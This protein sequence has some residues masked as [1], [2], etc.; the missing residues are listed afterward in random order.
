MAYIGVAIMWVNFCSMLAFGFID[1]L[2]NVKIASTLALMIAIPI[3]VLV[4]RDPSAAF[5]RYSMAIG[6]VLMISLIVF[7]FDGHPWQLDWHMYYF[8]A[9]AALA[10]FCCATTVLLG[11]GLIAV[12]H[13]LLN[14]VLPAAIFPDG[15]D[16]ARVALHAVIVVFET[17]ILVWLTKELSGSLMSAET[18][19][20]NAREAQTQAENMGRQ[21]EETQAAAEQR[22]KIDMA[23]VATDFERLVGQI[24]ADLASAVEVALKEAESLTNSAGGSQRDATSATNSA[25]SVSSGI[26]SVAA[27][28]E[29]LTASIHEISNQV[30]SAAGV[31]TEA[32]QRAVT[33]RQQVTELAEHAEQI[34]DIVRLIQDI[35]E[36]TNLLALNAT[37]EA[38]RAGEAGKGFAVVAGEVKSLALQTANATSQIGDRITEI[39]VAMRDAV[40]GISVISQYVDSINGSTATIASAVQQQSGATREIAGTA[41]RVAGGVSETADSISRLEE[42]TIHTGAAS[43]RVNT[44]SLQIRTSVKD[45][46]KQTSSF[47]SSLRAA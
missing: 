15:A 5:T 43:E 39:Q 33:V 19:V 21:M 28:A 47:V 9:L 24:I 40:S 2:T 46:E 25:H 22:R 35:A 18:A 3:T 1:E 34:G 20:T 37:I 11:A 27:A 8:A 7:E 44:I 16:F 13:V 14:F 26:Q 10:G 23:K 36:Q 17:G 32:T 4:A 42:A 29:E 30:S 6:Y 38:A 12:H 31:T 45:L 41:Q